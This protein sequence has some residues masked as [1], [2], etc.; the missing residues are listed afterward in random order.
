MMEPPPTTRSRDLQIVSTGV[1]I[2]REA[3]GRHTQRI[4][5]VAEGGEA[6]AVLGRCRRRFGSIGSGIGKWEAVGMQRQRQRL[7]SG[8][9][10][11]QQ[12]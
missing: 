8:D 10:E 9:W 1:V 11:A 3:E 2:N 12:R 4:S 5:E 6:S 7:V